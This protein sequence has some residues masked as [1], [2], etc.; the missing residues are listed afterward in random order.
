LLSPPKD[1][2]PL[3]EPLFAR[4]PLV[5]PVLD[6]ELGAGEFAG[7]DFCVAAG[8]DSVA[9]GEVAGGPLAGPPGRLAGGFSDVPNT[10][11]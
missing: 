3:V 2:L 4:S 1:H 6:E 8:A 5:S 11:L 10:S 9:A 7:S